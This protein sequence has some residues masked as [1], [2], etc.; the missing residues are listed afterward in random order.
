MAPPAGLEGRV[1]SL[2]SEMGRLRAQVERMAG[3]TTHSFP[4][5]GQA[6]IGYQ[7][8]ISSS[9]TPGLG[10]SPALGG[11][12]QLQEFHLPRLPTSVASTF[13]PDQRGSLPPL[14]SEA[15]AVSHTS[16]QMYG[17][18]E[19]PRRASAGGLEPSTLSQRSPLA[20]S[21]ASAETAGDGED[22]AHVDMSADLMGRGIVDENTAKIALELSV[23]PLLS[24]LQTTRSW[25]SR[26]APFHSYVSDMALHTPYI[27]FVTTPVSS[28]T[29]HRMRRSWVC[30]P[31]LPCV[32]CAVSDWSQF[33]SRSSVLFNATITI[34]LRALD[35][36]RYDE[37]CQLVHAAAA[38]L[39]QEPGRPMTTEDLR[40]LL[41]F[42][43]VRCTTL[44]LKILA[45]LIVCL[46]VVCRIWQADPTLTALSV[47]LAHS[48][49][50]HTA[51][52]RYV[53][54]SD[55]SSSE[56]AQLLDL[57]RLYT[58]I[59][60]H[61]HLSVRF[62]TSASS[63][64]IRLT[65]WSTLL[66]LTIFSS[67][68]TLIPPSASPTALWMTALS[69]GTHADGVDLYITTYLLFVDLL[70]SLTPTLTASYATLS[71]RLAA[72]AHAHAQV[73][74]WHTTRNAADS[75]ITIVPVS[76]AT[77]WIFS[78]MSY[79][80]GGSWE[81]VMTL[82]EGKRQVDEAT[83]KALL[84]LELLLKTWRGRP[85]V[86][87]TR[88]LHMSV[89]GMSLGHLLGRVHCLDARDEAV[90]GVMERLR[91]V[92]RSWEEFG[93]ETGECPPLSDDRQDLA[94]S[95]RFLPSSERDRWLSSGS[96]HGWSGARVRAARRVGRVEESEMGKGDVGGHRALG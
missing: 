12:Q 7:P 49:H 75:L 58:S 31:H 45:E 76:F 29:V 95:C 21:R 15:H 6:A 88:E 84:L 37:G 69:R 30:S 96:D 65:R 80:T 86:R 77:V 55:P 53:S 17:Y 71:D 93:L 87:Y 82:P 57:S 91:D 16:P 36:D 19:V 73:A 60:I 89:L 90:E 62:P 20:H 70:A 39:V 74:H 25:W 67:H 18:Q 14:T 72:T 64:C 81:T 78:P 9:S 66:R 23:R 33:I 32:R 27:P 83:E 41:L 94:H 40:G 11:S 47:Q 52:E 35:P 79:E 3:V 1:V 61:S 38:Q 68:P 5:I 48:L 26:P 2:E 10:A 42:S 63:R 22:M 13:R 28:E 85:M 34:A 51:L 4:A 44:C 92:L 8:S 54:L 24:D 50:L 59:Y 56:G 43:Y 46:F